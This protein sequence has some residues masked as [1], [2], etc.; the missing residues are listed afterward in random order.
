MFKL[1]D[2][3]R[4]K[5]EYVEPHEDPNTEY[6]VVEDNGDGKTKVWIHSGIS[7]FGGY[8]YVWPSEVFYKVGHIDHKK[9]S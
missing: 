6:L 2:I 4:I 1:G 5:K 8:H 7:S 9:G 3:V